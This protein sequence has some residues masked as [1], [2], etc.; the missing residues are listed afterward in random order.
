MRKNPERLE[1]MS[2]QL[3]S[4]GIPFS[5][6]E[7]VDGKIYDFSSIYDENL[8]KKLNGFPLS[9]VDRGCPVSHRKCLEK[10]LDEGLDYALILEDDVELPEDFK[11]ILEKTL[12][13]RENS[14]TTWEYLAFNYPSVGFKF[15]RL[16][17]YLLFFERFR[18]HATL[19]LYLQIP[20]FF[21][22]FVGI[23]LFSLFEGARDWFYKKVY[24]YG[25]PARFYRSMYL[26]GCYLVTKEGVKKLLSISDKLIYPAD[27]VQNIAYD[28]NNL[29]LFHFV[30]LIV[31][32]RRDKFESTMNQN[33]NYVFSKYD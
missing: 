7:G 6:Q 2:Q 30:P 16:W 21:I 31:K 22:K 27:R 26:A 11:D 20:F 1:F 10:I 33:K 19:S 28:R 17:L 29:K 18:N 32:Q 24:T 14:T 25:K 15:V 9:P 3:Q 12:K 23:L 4:L 5:I 13:E 8:S